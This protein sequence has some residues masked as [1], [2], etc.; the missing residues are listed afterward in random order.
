MIFYFSGTGNTFHTASLVAEATND[1]MISIADALTS[2]T[3]DYAL[4]D[5][6]RIGFFFP[7]HGWRP[8]FIVRKF[9]QSLHI[10]N[11][12]HTLCVCFRNM[13]R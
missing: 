11:N 10:E 9:I 5:N 2:Q 1:R 3:F 13:R 12:K 4:E 7:V 6:E 8:P